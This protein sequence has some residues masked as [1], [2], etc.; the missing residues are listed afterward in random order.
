MRPC[1]WKDERQVGI[2]GRWRAACRAWEKEQ[3]H[4]FFQLYIHRP[5]LSGKFEAFNPDLELLREG[6]C[7]DAQ[8]SAASEFLAAPRKARVA[9]PGGRLRWVR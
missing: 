5:P 1:Y 2:W 3:G 7:T 4:V 9:R 6:D 8:V